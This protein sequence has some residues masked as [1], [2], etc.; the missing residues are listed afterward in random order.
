[1]GGPKT[2]LQKGW[3][4]AQLAGCQQLPKVGR[5]GG[6]RG[7]KS[8]PGVCRTGQHFLKDLAFGSLERRSTHAG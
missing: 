4:P 6:S 8:L 5:M 2:D 3:L 7:E 1:M